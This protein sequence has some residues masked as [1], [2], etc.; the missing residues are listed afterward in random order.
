MPY[1]DWLATERGNV[2]VTND[3]ADLY[4]FFDCTYGAEFL[5]R[6][7][8]ETKIQQDVPKKLDYIK[9]HDQAMARILDTVEM[10]NMMAEDFIMFMRQNNWKLAKSRRE[11]EFA[12]LSQAE[13]V[14]L[15]SIVIQAFDGYEQ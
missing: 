13:V 1:I 3:T 14:L 5:Y 9:R 8:E 6:C 11:R 12:K 15:E 7:V 4:R 2:E 10:P